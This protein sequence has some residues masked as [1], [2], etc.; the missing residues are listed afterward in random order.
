M[1]S[2]D[3]IELLQLLT[4]LFD[5]VKEETSRNPALT[6]KGIVDI[7]DLMEKEGLPLPM[8][9]LSGSEKGVNLLTAHGSKGLE[10]EYVFFAGVNASA[11]E[12]KRKPG[13][14]YKL[15]DTMFSSVSATAAHEEE[16]LRRLFYVAITRAEKHLCISYAKLKSDGREMEPSMFIAEI[17]EQH[18]LPV[19]RITLSAEDTCR[20]SSYYNSATRLRRL[21]ERKMIL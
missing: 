18:Q 12:K 14:G 17:Q 13:G 8:V 5:F 1:Q 11:W 6:L 9:Q 21:K 4:A 15:P 16:E 20:N 3:K 2:S 7:I 19:E 10:F